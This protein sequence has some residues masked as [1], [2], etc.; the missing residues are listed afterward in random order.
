MKKV[1]AIVVCLCLLLCGCAPSFSETDGPVL[2]KELIQTFPF[3]SIEIESAIEWF[4]EHD[5]YEITYTDGTRI[6]VHY[7]GNVDWEITAACFDDEPTDLFSFQGYCVI[8]NS[9]SDY[10]EEDLRTMYN[11]IVD[12]LTSL[13]GNPV[14]TS[15]DGNDISFCYGPLNIKVGIGVRISLEM[16]Y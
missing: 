16:S 11:C 9:N 1:I 6:D 12:E 5:K 2:D 15:S 7:A 10:S 14:K 4:N 8:L 13:C 3:Y